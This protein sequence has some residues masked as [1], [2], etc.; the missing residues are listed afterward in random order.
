MLYCH[1]SRS[2]RSKM[3]TFLQKYFKTPADTI[4]YGEENKGSHIISGK[5]YPLW[6]LDS[7]FSS[8]TF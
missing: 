2:D 1:N 6:I 8:N 4:H 7:F 5:K 3:F